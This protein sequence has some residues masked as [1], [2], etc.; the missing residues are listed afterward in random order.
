MAR[1]HISREEA[2]KRLKSQMPISEKKA[3]ADIVID[4]RGSISETEKT[5]KKNMAGTVAREKSKIKNYNVK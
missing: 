1:N 2:Q 3:L 5:G 4:N